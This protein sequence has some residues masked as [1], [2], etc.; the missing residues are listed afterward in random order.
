MPILTTETITGI[1]KTAIRKGDMIRAKYIS[2]TRAINGIVAGVTVETITVLYI[3]TGGNVSNYFT[4]T[5]AE[6]ADGVW[7]L[8]WSSDFSSVSTENAASETE[9]GE[10]TEE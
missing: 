4:I 8:S 2:W 10:E 3:G 6:L 9:G 1:D 7:E 5:A